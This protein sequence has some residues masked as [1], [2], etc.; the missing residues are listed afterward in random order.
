M[1]FDMSVT[2][3]GLSFCIFGLLLI[4]F[5]SLCFFWNPAHWMRSLVK[6]IIRPNED[7][8]F[9]IL[10]ISA[11][12]FL[13]EMLFLSFNS[14]TIMDNKSPHSL[15]YKCINMDRAV[16]VMDIKLILPPSVDEQEH[17]LLGSSGRPVLF[18]APGSADKEHSWSQW[19]YF[20]T[21]RS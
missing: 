11:P 9:T 6:W 10:K 1:E 15:W 14:L 2:W 4:S 7:S 5:C 19:G 17:L 8:H 16:H 13:R 12:P 3:L 20:L 21:K 18:C